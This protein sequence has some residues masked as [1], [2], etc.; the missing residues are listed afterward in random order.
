MIS[1]CSFFCGAGRDETYE[2]EEGEWI[3][4]ENHGFIGSTEAVPN[5]GLAT[6]L[7]MLII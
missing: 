2:L 6:V 3:P 1:W 5:E 4:E 7:L